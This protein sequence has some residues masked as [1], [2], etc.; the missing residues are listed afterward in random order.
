MADGF[1]PEAF[2]TVLLNDQELHEATD[3]IA[4]QLFQRYFQGEPLKEFVRR[5]VAE[6]G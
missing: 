5:V 3:L 1:D 2:K 4:D 6:R